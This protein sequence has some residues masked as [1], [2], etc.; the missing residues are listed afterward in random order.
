MGHT[1]PGG[2]GRV[3]LNV[4]GGWAQL[5]LPS[6]QPRVESKR[7]TS[8][9]VLRRP[10][11][12]GEMLFCTPANLLSRAPGP[13]GTPA[14]GQTFYGAGNHERSTQSRRDEQMEKRPC[15]CR[16]SSSER[17]PGSRGRSRRTYGTSEKRTL[18]LEDRSTLYRG[19][20]NLLG[21]ARQ[22]RFYPSCLAPRQTKRQ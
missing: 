10:T 18:A 15:P 19:L 2:R 21:L 3:G 12:E 14:A 20:A 5:D 9:I 17:S 7:T 22:S 16:P 13:L 1:S 8:S 6:Q 4:L 11:Q